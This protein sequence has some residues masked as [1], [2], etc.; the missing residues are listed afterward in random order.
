MNSVDELKNVK[1]DTNSTGTTVS[2]SAPSNPNPND[3]TTTNP[4]PTNNQPATELPPP[5]VEAVQE[6]ISYKK[7]SEDD[8][9]RLYFKMLKMVFVVLFFIYIN[10]V[11]LLLRSF[12]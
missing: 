4:V 7:V 9:Y 2:T 10:F 5:V 1:L 8:R 11:L 3:T 12:F 6:Q